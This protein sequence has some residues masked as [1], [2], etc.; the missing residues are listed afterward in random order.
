MKKLGSLV[1]IAVATIISITPI[2]AEEKADDQ[3]AVFATQ[4]LALDTALVIAQGA[5]ASCREK[6]IHVGVTIVTRDGHPQVI[7][8]D[9]FA[10][11]I[12]ETVSRGKAYTAVMFNASTADLDSRSNTPVGRVPGLVMSR[13]GLTITAGGELV[14]GIG[15]SGAPMG[16]TDEDCAQDGLDLVQS[17]LDFL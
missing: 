9:T 13:G 8:R 17:E 12:T 10:S 1:S 2:F 15:V 16:Q 7:L 5:I 14:G 6:G 4:R 11:P 3:V